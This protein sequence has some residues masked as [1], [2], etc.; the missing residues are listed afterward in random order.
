MVPERTDTDALALTEPHP[1]PI[2]DTGPH[3]RPLTSNPVEPELLRLPDDIDFDSD[4]DS[5]F[6][7]DIDQD[8]DHDGARRAA[9]PEPV[10]VLVQPVAVRGQ[11]QYLKRWKFLL[12]LSGVWIVAAAAGSG[13]FYWWYHALDKT[14]PDFVVL[15]YVIVCMVGA[16]LVSMVEARP[17]M[18][19][20]A[21][22]VMSAPL[23]SAGA[24]AALY[25]MYVFGWVTP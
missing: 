21:V 22:A 7:Q 4:F 19:A 5:E 20:T 14:W 8:T 17:M 15:I 6:G 18:S 11:Y 2:F 3:P 10:P 23:A 25:G 16:M 1:A 13:F 24:A 9:T 12:V